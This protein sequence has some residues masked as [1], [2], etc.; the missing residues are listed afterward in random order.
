VSVVFCQVEVR[1]T[2]RI[3]RAEESYRLWCV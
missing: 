1:A 3:A 2:G